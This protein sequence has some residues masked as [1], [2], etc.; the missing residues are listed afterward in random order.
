M[1]GLGAVGFNHPPPHLPLEEGGIKKVNPKNG[2]GGKLTLIPL[3][4]SKEVGINI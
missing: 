2:G 1:I 3:K 4:R